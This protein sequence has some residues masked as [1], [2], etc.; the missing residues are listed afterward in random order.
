MHRYFFL[1]KASP[2]V[3]S[4]DMEDLRKK[5]LFSVWLALFTH[6]LLYF[7]SVLLLNGGEFVATS[8]RNLEGLTWSRR[9]AY[10]MWRIVFNNIPDF[11]SMVLY[12]KMTRHFNSTVQPSAAVDQNEEEQNGGIHPVQAIQDLDDEFGGNSSSPPLP[13]IPVEDDNNSKILQILRVHLATSLLDVSVNFV[14]LLP[15]P[16]RRVALFHLMLGLGFWV[17]MAVIKTNFK[18]M[19]NMVNTFCLL[20][21]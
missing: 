13:A 21:C 12:L 2:G 19:D 10:I 20:V 16:A 11:A 7:A 5:S 17:P 6:A 18:Q 1:V 3:E 4:V 15:N 14:L 9:V 8:A